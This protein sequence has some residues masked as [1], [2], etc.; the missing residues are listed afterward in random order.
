MTEDRDR[1]C[2]KDRR[3]NSLPKESTL[4]NGDHDPKHQDKIANRGNREP[5]R[6]TEERRNNRKGVGVMSYR[7][8]RL[9]HVVCTTVLTQYNIHLASTCVVTPFHI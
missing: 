4:K 6:E 3:D 8:I 2:D 5:D 7:T 1:T 9:I